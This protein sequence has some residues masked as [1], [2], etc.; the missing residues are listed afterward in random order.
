VLLPILALASWHAYCDL[1]RRKTTDH[2][3]PAPPAHA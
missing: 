1:T 2:P 3:T